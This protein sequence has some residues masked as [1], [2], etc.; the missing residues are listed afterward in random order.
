[1]KKEH[2]LYIIQHFGLPHDYSKVNQIVFDMFGDTCSY[3][4]DDNGHR[5][6]LEP[7]IPT[8]PPGL[9][10]R[11]SSQ[12]MAVQVIDFIKETEILFI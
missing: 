10:F 7:R 3:S 2:V 8:D 1:M 9:L 6:Q 4:C 5:V 11:V 12:E